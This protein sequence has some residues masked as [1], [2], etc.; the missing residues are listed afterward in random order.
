[1]PYIYSIEYKKIKNTAIFT[2][3]FLS[4]GIIILHFGSELNTLFFTVGIFRI[5]ILNKKII[6]NRHIRATR[7]LTENGEIISFGIFKLANNC[8]RF[9]NDYSC[10]WLFWKDFKKYKVKN[11]NLLLV[12]KLFK[13]DIFV[14]SES[15]VDKNDF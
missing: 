5:F 8:L 1:M 7:E 6:K 12:P 2:L 15:E 9:S 11:A 14:I 3:S 13:E 10:T 4:A